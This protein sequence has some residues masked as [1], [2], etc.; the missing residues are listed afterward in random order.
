V[1]AFHGQCR[2]GPGGLPG[3]RLGACGGAG[4]RVGSPEP[5]GCRGARQGACQ[6]DCGVPVCHA[7]PWHTGHQIRR[8][9]HSSGPS[10]AGEPLAVP[11]CLRPAGADGGAL[12]TPG[13]TA[14]LDG[15]RPDRRGALPWFH[16]ERLQRA[17]RAGSFSASGV[18]GSQTWPQRSHSA[19]STL[20]MAM[21]GSLYLLRHRWISFFSAHPYTG[22]TV[23]LL[24][25]VNHLISTLTG[26]RA[27]S[28]QDAP[29]TRGR[30]WGPPW[31]QRSP[32]RACNASKRHPGRV[33]D[34]L[35]R[36]FASGV[37]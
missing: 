28:A 4:E 10:P 26:D 2:R 1:C 27:W 18:A 13:D 30:L 20:L 11:A 3:T 9:G 34:L 7:C 32:Q 25:C 35:P 16:V 22:K 31:G 29:V 5:I 21:H 6:G 37:G 14:C 23:Q 12:G 8:C 19:A 36:R 17:H 33:P 24:D 15:G